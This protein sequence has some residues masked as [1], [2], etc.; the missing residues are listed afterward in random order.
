MLCPYNSGSRVSIVVLSVN[1]LNCEAVYNNHEVVR[2]NSAGVRVIPEGIRV[3]C[4]A[5]FSDLESRFSKLF[6]TPGPYTRPFVLA[7]FAS[8]APSAD[9]LASVLFFLELSDSRFRPHSKHL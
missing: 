6:P 4:E 7:A 5:A 2:N 9:S 1:F 8:V 3:R